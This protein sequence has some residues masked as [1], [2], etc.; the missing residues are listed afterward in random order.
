MSNITKDFSVKVAICVGAMTIL[1]WASNFFAFPLPAV[2]N[3]S[4]FS[5]RV[6]ILFNLLNVFTRG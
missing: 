5:V 4:I 6:T 2:D 1:F 3:S